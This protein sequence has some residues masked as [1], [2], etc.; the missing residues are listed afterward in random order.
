[1]ILG[2]G[3][4]QA[5]AQVCTLTGTSASSV[6]VDNASTISLTGLPTNGTFSVT[7]DISNGVASGE[8]VS[9]VSSDGSGNASFSTVSL[10]CAAIGQTLTITIITRTDIAGCS[11]APAGNNTASL[12]VTDNVPPVA[13]CKNISVNL[14]A[15]GNASVVGSDLDDGSSDN[16]GITS[17][18]VVPNT[19]DC[20]TT[21]AQSVTVFVNDGTNIDPCAATVTVTDVTA[22]T[23][24]C[25]SSVVSLDA[26]GNWVLLAASIEASSSDNCA[27]TTSTVS[28]N[29]FTCNDI[30]DPGVTL[31]V[32]DAAGNTATCSATVTV[33]DVTNPD[34][35]CQNVT[36]FLDNTGNLTID[37]SELDNGSSDACGAVTFAA[38]PSTFTCASV[39]N[40]NMT[41]TVTDQ[42]TN[43]STCSAA[44]NISSVGPPNALC[45]SAIV[46]LDGTGNGTV[47]PSDLDNG[48][49]GYCG[50]AISSF[51]AS[52]NTFDCNNLGANTVTLTV[53][54]VNSQTA[55]CTAT[56][57]VQ[58]NDAP[59]I[60][61]VTPNLNLD[62][63]GEVTLT[64]NDGIF[65]QSDNCAITTYAYSPSSFDCDDIGIGSQGPIVQ[66]VV[67]DASNNTTNCFFRANVSDNFPPTMVCQNITLALDN[68][69]Q[70]SIVISDIDN[71]SSD[72]CGLSNLSLST[73]NFD[74]DD[75]GS[76]TITLTATDSENNTASCAANV[77]VED[78]IPPTALCAN[79][80][81]QLDATGNVNI[82]GSDVDN[83]SS[84]NCLGPYGLALSQKAF[85]C[86]DTGPQGST[87]VTLTVTDVAGNTSDCTA[88]ITVE[89][90]LP[91]VA[92]CQD[93]TVFLDANGNATA[94]ASDVDNN[95]SDNC[96]IDN[97][98]LS[99]TAFSC[100]DVGGN[101]V[102]LTVTD[103]SGNSSTCSATVTVIDKTFPNANCLSTTVFLDASGNASILP[104]DVSAMSDDNCP[105]FVM[106]V[107][108]NTF[109]CND[110]DINPFTLTVTDASSNSASCSGNLTIADNLSPTPVC[111][112]ITVTLD[113]AGDVSI[114]G[115]DI[116]G[117]STDNCE[118]ASQVASPSSFT[119]TNIGGNNVTLTV[120]DG[121]SNS[122][123]CVAVVT[124]QETQAPNAV[125]QNGSVFLDATGNISLPASDVDNGS[126][127]NCS[128][129]SSVVS[130][131]AF[132]CADINSN[133]HTVTLTVTDGSNN[134]ASCDASITV[135]D[136]L[137]PVPVCN[138]IAVT[139]DA[140]AG[141]YSLT[142][143]DVSDIA[144]GS[145]DN[146]GIQS[147]TVSPNTFDC[148]STP[149]TSVTLT[150]TDVNGN[151]ATC[152]ATVTVDDNTPPI[153][154]CQDVTVELDGS[155]NGTAVASD[156][157]NGSNDVC[158]IQSLDISPSTFDCS[159]IG[160]VTVTLTVTDNNGNTSNCTANATVQDNINPTAVCQTAIV[161]L[162]A[163]GNGTLAGSDVDGGSSD[164]CGSLTLDVSPGTFDCTH[165]GGSNTAT[166]TVTDLGGNTAS[167]TA[168]VVVQD[169][170]KPT[171]L[172]ETGVIVLL[173]GSG[174]GSIATSDIDANSS[175]ACGVSTTTISPTTFDC[176]TTGSQSVVLTVT[177]VNSNSSNCTATV[178]V[179]DRI[180]P[181]A[182]CQGTTVSLDA[183]GSASVTASTIDNGSSDNCSL[184]SITVNPSTFD[185]NDL[186]NVT[187]TL[188]VED[189]SGN[190][191]DCTAVVVVEDN[192]DPTAICQS[193]SV[194]LDAN[195]EVNLAAS[196]VDNGSSDNCAMHSLG[197]SPNTFECADVGPNN[198]TLTV[199]DIANNTATCSA[200]VTI[201]DN[202]APTAIC[203]DATV[204]VDASGNAS[205]V[206]SDVDNNSTDNCG[207]TSYAVNPS[208]FDCSTVGSVT[209]TL[210]LEDLAGN[211][212]SCTATVS[213][214]DNL[215]PTA[216]CQDITVDLDAT[217]NVAIVASQIDNG[218]T[219]N[220]PGATI[221]ANPTAFTCQT[222]GDNTVTLTV[223]DASSN[224]TTCSANVHVDDVTNPTALCQASEEPLSIWLVES[225]AFPAASN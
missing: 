205:I 209:V 91:P 124:V 26:S 55:N 149:S 34:A 105:N 136:N 132:D 120:T 23:V 9:G 109:D 115:S 86:N 73:Q 99:Q 43:S 144:N 4:Q 189:P 138:D 204:E 122:A 94:A 108:P 1:M 208:T 12:T 75:V 6:N 60:S 41:V 71:G 114:V 78:N 96:D 13:K 172:C 66:L 76:G 102:T 141:T 119:C 95:S 67:S 143:G 28:P 192:I 19:F 77:E 98:A 90:N 190:S 213:A 3:T 170:E 155:G 162:D 29:S 103:V 117:G 131:N 183:N 152:Q 18:T 140:Q 188:T 48:S 179:Q 200:T 107:S 58:D 216:T 97:L 61:C 93:V 40:I 36:L 154:I 223:T 211:Q 145:S 142:T 35:Q 57:D 164:N 65:A 218:S 127:D 194:D 169:N 38:N 20:T 133:P 104:S 212:S 129:V 163:N 215:V 45:Q 176:S 21:G 80:T 214:Q 135:V 7:Y 174:F 101:S 89:D 151:S 16:C 63:N 14:D 196:Q 106:V 50:A 224:T 25:Q 100:A 82:A 5:I 113:G 59:S 54:D 184:S 84:D 157:D 85:D 83:N 62:I 225:V 2:L 126:S 44:L 161:E 199:T 72:A 27:V 52:P 79:Q 180:S 121:E 220:C 166:L 8:V 168:N 128:I 88:D 203:Q 167:C 81:I 125:C 15:T 47:I 139:L 68:N 181:T 64:P 210:D 10:P 178:D 33:Q 198:V 221:A 42:N 147:E 24:T 31:T 53:T 156:V 150:V 219:D 187:V 206:V 222:L 69:G 32:G 191:D 201:E 70:A 134:S 148:S 87:Q 46:V 56:V 39:G 17:I 49:T 171:P 130:P 11:G 51:A 217:G 173:D 30:G 22:P 175:D 110:L 111:Q 186:G 195:G 159:Q 185:C 37:G 177:D 197:V 153:A 207:I 123:N 202:T 165:V 193:I 160:S 137:P 118:V 92:I 116:D 74:C 112:N 182:I 158:G 146:C